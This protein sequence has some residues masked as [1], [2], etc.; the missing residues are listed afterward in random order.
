MPRRISSEEVPIPNDPNNRKIY[1]S[2]LE[3][4]TDNNNEELFLLYSTGMENGPGI[5]RD[6]KSA[7]WMIHPDPKYLGKI[8]TDPDIQRFGTFFIDTDSK[9]LDC[10]KLEKKIDRLSKKDKNLIA[11]LQNL[12]ESNKISKTYIEI[13][14]ENYPDYQIKAIQGIGDLTMNS[15]N[16]AFINDRITNEPKLLYLFDEPI[17]A[18]EYSCLIKWK[19]GRSPTLQ[20]RTIKFNGFQYIR[21]KNDPRVVLLNNEPIADKIE[22]AVYG[23]LVIK[24]KSDQNISQIFHPK[25]IIHQFS[26][27]RHIFQLPNLNPKDDLRPREYFGREQYDDIWFGEAELIDSRN[28]R[29]AAIADSVEFNTLYCGLGLSQEK[30][31]YYMKEANYT[32]CQNNS[33]PLKY[34]Q[35]PSY[36]DDQWTSCTAEW[37][38]VPEEDNRLVEIRIRENRYPC[39]I[40]GI[41]KAGKLYMQAWNGIYSKFPGWTLR[42]SANNLL[43]YG[44]ESAILCDEGGDVFQYLQRD[45]NIDSIIKPSRGQIRA[46]FILAKK[47]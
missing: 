21:D 43:Q 23:Q 18:R 5:K 24:P 38:F 44:V 13:F 37:R 46:V 15:W 8:S 16:V 40:L 14:N 25:D 34:D 33:D 1:R 4:D 41:N 22:F 20:I 17:Y 35:I 27:M 10:T 2:V 9:N 42:Q 47:I 6:G 7:P 28:L 3:C 31:R 39:T 11:E 45:N 30:C 19:D 32:E 36:Q 29:K 26:D 12:L